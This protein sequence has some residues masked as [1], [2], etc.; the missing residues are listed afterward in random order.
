MARFPAKCVKGRCLLYSYQRLLLG[1]SWSKREFLQRLR[2]RATR[3]SSN[4]SMYHCRNEDHWET[5]CRVSHTMP[6]DP[7]G[8]IRTECRQS[9]QKPQR[10]PRTNIHDRSRITASSKFN[11]RGSQDPANRGATLSSGQ[12]H[13][14]QRSCSAG[15]SRH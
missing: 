4:M 14:R 5:D 6:R 7:R 2:S 10:S 3:C 12:C 8:R 15:P 11:T 13:M 9:Y 1:S